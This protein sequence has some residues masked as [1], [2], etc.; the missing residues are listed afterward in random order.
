MIGLKINRGLEQSRVLLLVMSSNASE[1]EWVTFESQTIL[2]SDPTN[3]KRRFIPL[4]LD[5][6]KIRDTLKQ[7]AYIDWHDRS[8]EQY[9]RLLVAC[10]PHNVVQPTVIKNDE[11]QQDGLFR[12]HKSFVTSIAIT[13]NGQQI[14]S[15]SADSTIK[16]WDIKNGL[17]LSTLE[18][19]S[20]T[21]AAIAVTPDGEQIVSGSD[22]STIKI[23]GVKNGICQATLKGHSSIVGTIAVTPDGQYIVSGSDDSTIKIWDIKDGTCT[24]TLEGHSSIVWAIAITPNGHQ[25]VSGSYDHTIKIWDV[26]K[27]TCL[28]TLRGI[29]AL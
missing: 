23:W 4:R 16:I 10:S 20:T 7:F 27:G 21:V 2:F 29:Q 13:P 3:Q 1:S 25:I 22:D 9:V 12:G 24:N 8:P 26:K 5:N 18:G 6:F 15:G 17:C 28:A 14:V 11:I 19:N